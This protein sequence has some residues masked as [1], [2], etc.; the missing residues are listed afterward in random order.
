MSGPIDIARPLPGAA[1][2]ARVRLDRSLAAEMPGGLPQ[3]LAGAGGLLLIPGLNEINHDPALLVG[4]SRLFGP[5][6]EDYRYLPTGRRM[7]HETQPEIFLVTNTVPGA[8]P[9]PVRPE[10]PLTAEGK[11][12]VQYPH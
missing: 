10:P 8:R 2:G 5:E 6:V 9:P 12:P 1:F 4:L 7:V 11:L 3:A